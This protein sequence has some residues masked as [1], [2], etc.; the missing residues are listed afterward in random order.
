MSMKVILSL[1]LVSS[2]MFAAG[3]HFLYDFY[4]AQISP[5]AVKYAGRD[6]NSIA[7]YEKN[8]HTAQ[9]VRNEVIDVYTGEQLR[10]DYLANLNKEK[11]Q[12]VLGVLDV[13]IKQ[14]QA[15]RQSMIGTIDQPGWLLTGLLTLLPVG[16][17]VAG[18]RTL[19]PSHYTEEEVKAEVAKATATT[20]TTTA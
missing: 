12:Q 6:A 20:T 13:S 2:I 1:I 18:W 8:L 4:P 16:S 3:C 11:Y 19:W 17:Y 14:A 5:L 9:E 10:L 15:D 7:W